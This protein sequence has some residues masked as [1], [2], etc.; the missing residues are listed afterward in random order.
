VAEDLE[1][2]LVEANAEPVIV[3]AEALTLID[4]T[5]LASA[6]VAANGAN[7]NGHIDEGTAAANVTEL[8][9]PWSPPCPRVLVRLLGPPAVEGAIKPVTAQQLSGLAY[10]ATHKPTTKSQVM[11]ALWGDKPPGERR[12]RDFLSE[13]RS[14]IPGGITI[15]PQVTDGVVATTDDL[16]SDVG[17]MEAL[18]ARAATHPEERARCLQGATDL[19]RGV[20]FTPADPKARRYWRW[21]E[22]DYVDG[23]VFQQLAQAGH[24]LARIYLDAGDP[25][26]AMGVAHKL[27]S[28]CSLDPGLTEVLM[29]AYAAMGSVGAAERV[30]EA[31]DAALVDACGYEGASEETR[32]VLER[33]RRAESV[34][35]GHGRPLSLVRE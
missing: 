31:H 13:L 10:L 17:Q 24:D 6:P 8:A 20:P 23:R 29:E 21:V 35:V 28:A 19:L 34:G 2:L 18:L 11:E 27:L 26:A 15:V 1:A 33:I 25:E 7:G 9:T 4:P 5:S 32:L 3:P 16:G 12:W 14:T 22:M 30:F